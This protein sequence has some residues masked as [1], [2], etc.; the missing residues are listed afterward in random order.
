MNLFASVIPMRYFYWPLKTPVVINQF[1]G[2]NKA[3]VSNKDNKTT[4]SKE[5]KQSCPA[6]FRSVYSKMKGHNGLDLRAPRWT[7]VYASREGRVVEVETE[8]ERGLGVGI[9]HGPYSNK[10][11]KTRYW[12]LAAI[13]VHL[14]ERVMTGQLIGYADSTG[15]STGDHLH[16]EIKETDNKGN[17]LNNGNGYFG[18]VNPL[19]L[20]YPD[21]ARGVH[22][23]RLMIERV[24]AA[25]DKLSDL[26]RTRKR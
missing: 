10:Y 4:V 15:F 21:E 24:A 12:H 26:L 1:F 11:Y 9:L 5:T 16:F 14:D 25:L 23:T 6:G 2:E 13:D 8:V 19:P 20:M 18:A 7:P 22:V 3:C 17:T